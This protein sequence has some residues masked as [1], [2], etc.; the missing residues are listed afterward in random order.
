MSQHLRVDH[1]QGIIHGMVGPPGTLGAVRLD[2][3]AR[4]PARQ[5]GSKSP[6]RRS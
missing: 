4:M 5:K 2:T 3:P 6:L 1:I